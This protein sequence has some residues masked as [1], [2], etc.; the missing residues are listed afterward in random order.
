MRSKGKGGGPVR[1]RAAGERACKPPHKHILLQLAP[2][3]HA[4]QHTMHA[5][6]CARRPS[7]QVPRTQATYSVSSWSPTVKAGGQPAT[8]DSPRSPAGPR[9]RLG[10]NPTGHTHSRMPPTPHSFLFSQASSPLPLSAGSQAAAIMQRHLSPRSG[11]AGM[12]VA[13]PTERPSTSPVGSKYSW[14]KSYES[15]LRS[16]MEMQ[17]GA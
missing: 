15:V 12:M 8:P 3:H 4:C 16:S 6:S 10:R 7:L 5:P 11:T 14:D 13:S 9:E 1:S 17:K 2:M